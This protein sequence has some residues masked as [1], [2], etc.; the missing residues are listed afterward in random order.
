MDLPC[1]VGASESHHVQSQ[2]LADA[3]SQNC[4]F[5]V[6]LCW[7]WVIVVFKP[8]TIITTRKHSVFVFDLSGKN[9]CTVHVN[10][11]PAPSTMDQCGIFQVAANMAILF[12]KV[13]KT[14]PQNS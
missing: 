4:W 13:L 1:A 6:Q 9:Y 14:S 2:T 12:L 5:S 8:H 7:C 3:R 10:P 11:L